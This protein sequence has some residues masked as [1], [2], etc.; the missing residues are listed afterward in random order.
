[1]NRHKTDKNREEKQRKSNLAKIRKSAIKVFPTKQAALLRTESM[2]DLNLHV[3]KYAA[4]HLNDE[5][6]Q[7][8]V[9][10]WAIVGKGG[11]TYLC[12]DGGIR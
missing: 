12:E 10:G 5:G 6:Q 2:T 4:W 1:M 11:H 8:L 7:C 9:T 3:Q